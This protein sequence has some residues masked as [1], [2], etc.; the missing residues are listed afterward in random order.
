[1]LAYQTMLHDVTPLRFNA[2]LMK[3]GWV[4][5]EKD[6]ALRFQRSC[7]TVEMSVAKIEAIQAVL[8]SVLHGLKAA[9]PQ[10]SPSCIGG[11]RVFT[12]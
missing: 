12:K 10:L 9:A 7:E 4:L 5:P 2:I 11:E 3:S 1:M 6:R 8:A